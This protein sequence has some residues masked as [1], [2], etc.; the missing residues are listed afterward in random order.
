METDMGTAWTPERKQRQREAIQQWK[1][2]EKSTGPRTPEGKAIVSRNAYRG[3][4]W[5]RLRF[6]N[7]RITALIKEMKRMGPWPPRNYH[8]N[9][10]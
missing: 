7:V 5:L 9:K 1:P 8:G 2:W 10:P 4:V 6:L 3:A